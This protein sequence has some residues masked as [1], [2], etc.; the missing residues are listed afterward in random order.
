[1]RD[2]L[3][4]DDLVDAYIMAVEQRDKV[5][6]KIF[7]IGG[8]PDQTLSVWAEFRPLLEEFLGKPIPTTMSDWRPG[9]Q[10]VYI[11]DIR[12]AGRELGWRPKT[13]VR[14]GVGRLVAWVQANVDLFQ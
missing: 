7:N 2:V 6:G 11:S 14:D 12:T 8:G 3:F 1:V 10:P 4:I 9:D 5:S 13:T